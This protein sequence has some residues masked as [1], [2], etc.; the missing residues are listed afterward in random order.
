MPAMTAV[1]VVAAMMAQ[2]TP[3]HAAVEAL[4]GAGAPMVVFVVLAALVGAA[5]GFAVATFLMRRKVQPLAADATREAALRLIAEQ[6]QAAAQQDYQKLFEGSVDGIYVTTPEGTILNANRALARVMGFDTPRALIDAIADVARDVYVDAADRDEYQRRM[7]R[8]GMVREFEYRARARDGRVVWLSDSATVVRDRA[9]AIVRYEGTVRDITNQMRTERALEEARRHLQ[10]VIDTV[11]AVI[12]VKDTRLRYILMNRYMAGVFGIEPEAAIGRTTAELMARYGETKSDD[13]DR[14]LLATG[15]ELGFY[16]EEYLDAAGTLRQWMVN[17]V[18]LRG[19]DGAIQSIVTVALDIGERKRNE[20]EMR[21][22]RDA[23]E[24]ALV[25]LRATQDS[26]IETEKLAALGR[27]VA[28]VAHEVNNP[29]GIGLTV[30]SSLERRCALFAAEVAKGELRRSHLTEFIAANR[31]AAG[32]LVANLNR[33]AELI[34]SFKQVAVDRNFS[35]RRSF[36]VGDLT[37]QLVTSLRPGSR[38]QNLTLTVECEPGIEMNSYP[39]SYGQVLTNLFLNAVA[40]A[41]SE[42]APGQIDIRVRSLGDDEVE[43]TFADNGCGMSVEVRRHAF[44]P[45]Y[46]TRRDRGG[47][48][49]G[50]HIVHSLVTGRLGGRLSLES[51]PG[52]GTRI[53]IVLPRA[54]PLDLAAE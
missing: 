8:D 32:Q 6:R 2:A 26:L 17:K 25:N 10:Q 22:A 28:G 24:A 44:D 5:A 1:P 50:L 3:A 38:K 54:G 9:G 37:E 11:P 49:L 39:G 18:P 15:E 4:S 13:N 16:E 36:D 30:A 53:E 20:Q 27:L 14:Q 23:A 19:A 45:F 12:N 47:T 41:F 35:H 40:H 29:V 33:A 43:L 21:K 48:G 31:D 42:G 34:Q 51:A 7:A 52:E 46:T